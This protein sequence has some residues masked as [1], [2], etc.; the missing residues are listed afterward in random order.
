M[1]SALE[2]Y[3]DN[4]FKLFINLTIRYYKI[5]KD[6]SRKRLIYKKIYDFR[7]DKSYKKKIIYLLNK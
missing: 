1:L 5:G 6:E 2:S 3:R 4:F 7:A